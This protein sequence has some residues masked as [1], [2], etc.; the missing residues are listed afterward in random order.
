MSLGFKIAMHWRTL[1]AFEPLAFRKIDVKSYDLSPEY[2]QRPIFHRNIPT[3][4]RISGR[5]LHWEM[6]FCAG[7]RNDAKGKAG[8]W[9]LILE[10]IRIALESEWEG[11]WLDPFF[12][13]RGR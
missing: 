2:P 10:S 11:K 7:Q 5:R 3:I 6:D 1:E 8:L 9:V 4:M 12:F 13:F